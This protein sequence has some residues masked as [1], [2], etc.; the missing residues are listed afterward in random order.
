MAEATV[1]EHNAEH[2]LTSVRVG[3]ARA[4]ILFDARASPSLIQAN[5][6]DAALACSEARE[7]VARTPGEDG[8]LRPDGGTRCFA[9]HRGR[10]SLASHAKETVTPTL[11]HD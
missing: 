8:Q 2:V 1:L 6:V 4:V 7:R 5:A 9:A 10:E 11:T 3:T